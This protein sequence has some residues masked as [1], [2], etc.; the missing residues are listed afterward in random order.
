MPK[1]KRKC[2]K[3]QQP[4]YRKKRPTDRTLH[5]VTEEQAQKIEQEWDQYYKTKREKELKKQLSEQE[6]HLENG[7]YGLYRNSRR[8]QAELKEVPMKSLSIYLE[9]LF[10]DVNGCT[11]NGTFELH[12]SSLAIGAVNTVKNLI[13]ELEVDE[14]SLHKTFVAVNTPISLELDTPLDPQTAWHEKIKKAIFE[15]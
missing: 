9:V 3:C 8:A 2:P 7:D 11:N 4:V 10:W 12:R 5:L 15:N 13:E 14:F 1:R 6:A